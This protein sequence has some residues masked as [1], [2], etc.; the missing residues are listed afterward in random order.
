MWERFWPV[1]KR[2][3]KE[4]TDITFNIE[5]CDAHLNVYSILFADLLL[6]LGSEAEN[7]GKS[8]ISEYKLLKNS[9]A[10]ISQL[11]FPDIGKLLI[12]PDF[13]L[14]NKTVSIIWPY[15]FLS[16]KNVIPFRS[17]G[18]NDCANP[19][20]FNNYNKVKHNRESNINCAN[21][22]S[23]YEALAGVFILNLWLQKK[24]F[25][26]MR[27]IHIDRTREYIADLSDVF[28]ADSFAGLS[29]NGGVN[30][31]IELYP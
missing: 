21:Y 3:E 20:W 10:G 15:C 9:H 18:E 13:K 27:P 19:E 1:Y 28:N 4:F 17:W 16:N 14:H 8:I 22:K 2:L 25:D 6:R 11:N 12:Q 30:K 23:V 31:R 29:K 7:L 26:N 24:N 5:F